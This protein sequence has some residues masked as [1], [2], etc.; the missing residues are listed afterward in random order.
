M[1]L[2]LQEIKADVFTIFAG[3]DCESDQFLE[4]DCGDGATAGW[5]LRVM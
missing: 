1:L 4:S 5:Q 3:K 2:S